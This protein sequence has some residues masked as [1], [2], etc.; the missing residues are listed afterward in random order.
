MDRIYLVT[1]AAGHLGSA[2]TLRLTG[3]GENV[4]ALLLP[5]EKYVPGNA[6]IFYGDVRDR[7][8]MKPCFENTDGR[9]MIVIHCA[10]I[11][12]IASGFSQT[13]HDVNVGGTVNIIDLCREYGVSKLVYVS[14]V[15]AIA[16]PPAG[17]VITE[18]SVF[19]PDKVTGD[20]AKTKAE[21]TSLVLEAA[22]QGLNACVVHPSGLVGPYDHGR[23][24]MTA[25]VIDYCKRRLTSGVGGGYDFAD[26]RDV[27]DGILSACEKGGK[28]ECYILSNRYF[29]VSEM[30]D[31]LHEI[32]GKRR[33]ISYLPHWFIKG[34]APLA[35]LYYRMLRRPPLFTSYSLY[36]LRSNA[37]FSHEKATDELGYTVRDMRETLTDTVAWLRENDR[38]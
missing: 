15:H 29:K 12:S 35:E 22:G 6:E 32:T 34:A 24:H 1:G 30:L 19:S 20:Y 5:G 17:T 36:T 10:G 14:S 23:G 16:E 4:R 25:L 13:L 21:A 38:L 26:V 2:V 8:S 33:I 3:A 37:L 18:T 28:G 7:E 11:V 9:E 31:M 27:A